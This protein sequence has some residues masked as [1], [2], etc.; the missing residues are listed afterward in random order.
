MGSFLKNASTKSI[1]LAPFNST[2]SEVQNLDDDGKEKPYQ[3]P[4]E[5]RRLIVP[6]RVLRFAPKVK[7]LDR[8]YEHNNNADLDNGVYN[9][10]DDPANNREGEDEDEE[11]SLLGSF[12]QTEL[13][14]DDEHA[15]EE[16]VVRR[17][18]QREREESELI[19][20]EKQI[21]MKYV[22]YQEPVEVIDRDLVNLI[23]N[24]GGL[25]PK[26]Y[27]M[28]ALQSKDMNYATANYHLLLKKQQFLAK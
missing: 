17:Q 2:V 28:R 15:E 10:I 26:E 6:K 16:A 23:S 13:S 11:D 21:K 25:Y 27:L 24:E 14:S 9:N 1:I 18:R 8:Q 5:V 7:D 19:E 4:D 22:R 3:W 12:K 20:F